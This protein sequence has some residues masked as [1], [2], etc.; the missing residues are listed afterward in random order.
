MDIKPLSSLKDIQKNYKKLAKNL[1]SD[2]G[3]NEE[4]MKEI[5]EAYKILKEY[6]EN[7]KFT[8]NE[9]EITKQYP[10]EFIKKFRV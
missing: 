1:H 8:F 3:G 2:K 9:E 5:N 6:I 10:G 4:K 7:Y